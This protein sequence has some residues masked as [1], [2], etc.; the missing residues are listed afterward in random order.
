[1]LNTLLISIPNSQ[2]PTITPIQTLRLSQILS[3]NP[4]S[5][6][7]VNPHL[8]KKVEMMLGLGFKNGVNFSIFPLVANYKA[9]ISVVSKILF[10]TI[11]LRKAY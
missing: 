2:F 11:Y 6:I 4:T 7:L 5:F 8:S 3:L 9:R 10:K 1:M